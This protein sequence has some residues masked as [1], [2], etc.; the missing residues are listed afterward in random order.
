MSIKDHYGILEIESSATLQEIKKSYRRLALQ[1]HPDKNNN[2]PYAVARFSE[3]KEAYEVLTHPEKKEQYL[4]QRWYEQS[5]GNKRKQVTVTPFTILKQVLELE[6]YVSKLDVFRMN[7]Y[8]LHDHIAALLDDETIEKLNS[9]NERSTNDQVIM[10]LMNCLKILPLDLTL[11]LYQQL[12][13]IETSS[14]I[15]EKLEQFIAARQRSNQRDKYKIWVI[16]AVVIVLCFV[17]LFS[18]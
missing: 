11:S 5:I 9:F 12:K 14:A 6:K 17:I 16:I 18:S 10:L 4:Q 15:R 1:F 2:D 3:I 8:G 13:K 7:K